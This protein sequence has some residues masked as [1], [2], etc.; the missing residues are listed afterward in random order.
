[1]ADLEKT[2]P[3]IKLSRIKHIIESVEKHFQEEPDRI[4]DIELSFE[5]IIGS[6]YPDVYKN[7]MDTLNSEHTRGYIQGYK[8]AKAEMEGKK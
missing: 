2:L 5:F 1:M 4:E 3:N 6:L 8:D 7:I